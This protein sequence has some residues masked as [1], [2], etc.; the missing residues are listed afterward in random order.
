M[1]I[2]ANK[3]QIIDKSAILDTNIIKEKH[4]RHL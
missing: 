3:V 2:T 1:Q 4:L